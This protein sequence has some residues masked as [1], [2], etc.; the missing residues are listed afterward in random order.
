MGAASTLIDGDWL[1][2]SHRDMGAHLVRGI[3][4]RQVFSQY[5]CRADSPTAGRDGN[6]HFGDTSKKILS[7][8]SHMGSWAPVA[9]GVAAAMQYQGEKG[10]ALCF[11]GDGASSQGVV[12][13]S[14]NYAAVFKLPVVFVINNNGYAISTPYKEQTAVP[15]LSLR[16]AGYGIPGK[17]IDGNKIVDV[18]QAAKEA[19]DQARTGE[20]PSLIECKTMRMSGHGT[21]D[22]ATYIPKETTEAWKKRDPLIWFKNYLSEKGMLTDAEDQKMQKKIDQEIEEAVDYARQQP[23]TK[24]EDLLK[25]R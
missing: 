9:N 19:V 21:H 16:A 12:H 13:E 1:A 18:Y 14:L 8:V 15:D 6:V 23:M 2:P 17:T 10:V 20:G 7:F 24:P 4:L 3:T 22:T 25:E 11:F 5:F